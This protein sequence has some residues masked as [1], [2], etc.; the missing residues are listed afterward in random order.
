MV[1]MSISVVMALPLGAPPT[2]CGNIVPQHT[3]VDNMASG[4]VPFE[5]DISSIGSSYVPNYNYT[6]KYYGFVWD[7]TKTRNGLENGLANE[8]K[9]T[10]LK[11][12]F[13]HR[14]PLYS[15]HT[16]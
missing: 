8:L 3:S 5:V 2:A 16:T 6:S 7:M 14:N 4:P 9:R 11:R 12:S 15:E 10:C 13:G 1:A